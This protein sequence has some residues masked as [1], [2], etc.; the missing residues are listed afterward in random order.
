MRRL[1][2]S[3]LIGGLICISLLMS[4]STATLAGKPQ[5]T[6]PVMG[7]AIDQKVYLDHEGKRIYFCCPACIPAFQQDP[8]KYLKKME[9]AGVQLPPAGKKP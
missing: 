2:W 1:P 5:T 9:D 7:G 6:C 4:G 8:A 3:L